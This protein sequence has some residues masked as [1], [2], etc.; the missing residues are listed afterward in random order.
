MSLVLF[1]SVSAGTLTTARAENESTLAKVALNPP[2]IASLSLIP[3][4]TVTFQVNTT[5][6]S[7]FAG[8]FVGFFYNI[9]VLT[10]PQVDYTNNVLDAPGNP[11][12]V[13]SECLNGLSLTGSGNVCTPDV[14]VDGLG[15]LSLQ[16]ITTPPLGNTTTPNGKLFSVTFTVATI[17]FSSIHFVEALLG[18]EPNGA[19]LLVVTN[20]GYFTNIDCPT[21]SGNLCKPPVVSFTPPVEPGINQPELFRGKAV[22]QNTNGVITEYNWTYGSGFD[23]HHYNSPINVT[24]PPSP[25]ATLGFRVSGMNEVTLSAQDNY[26]ARAYY[27]VSIFVVRSIVTGSGFFTDASLS[28]LP[29]YRDVAVRVDVVL[30]NGVVRTTNPP[31]ILAWIKV[32]NTGDIALQSLK[33]NET[34]PVDWRVDPAWMPGKGA[35]HV[36]FANTTSLATNPEITDP[37]TITVTGGNPQVVILAIPSLNDTGIGHPLLP[38][39][40]IL[41]SVKISFGLIGTSQFPTSRPREYLDVANATGWS[42]SLYLGT[43]AP[44]LPDPGFPASFHMNLIAFPRVVGHKTIA[45]I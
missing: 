30:A 32:S 38:G 34:L 2:S 39:D 11:A 26:G 3:G 37:S 7:P 28:P 20:D 12:T 13:L 22:S 14:S 35:I 43:E 45:I 10:N 29:S 9:S 18:T 21:G 15:V 42:Q 19:F 44:N 8:F 23:M 4:S 33:V 27:T 41:M 6:A 36:Y 31:R 17:G 1:T 5:N 25:N 24:A 16:L 40:S